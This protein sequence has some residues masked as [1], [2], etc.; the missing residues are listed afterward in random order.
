M[1]RQF[2]KSVAY[3]AAGSTLPISLISN[4][5][6]AA[7][8][9]MMIPA[10]PGGGWDGTGRAIGK[11]LI[12]TGDV[13]NVSYDNKGGALAFHYQ[14]NNQLKNLV[15]YTGLRNTELVGELAYPINPHSTLT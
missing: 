1:R 15:G 13:G 10:N 9:K 3:M 4:A 7:N 2:V 12:E 6:A 5:Q 14:T 8:I 11:A